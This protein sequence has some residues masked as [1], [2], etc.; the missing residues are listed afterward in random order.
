MEIGCKS[1]KGRGRLGL[2]E[3]L[4]FNLVGGSSVAVP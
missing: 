2:C 4:T 1:E 3:H